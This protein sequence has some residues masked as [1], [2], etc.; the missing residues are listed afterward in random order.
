MFYLPETLINLAAEHSKLQGS[1]KLVCTQSIILKQNASDI[2]P[3]ITSVL[4][5]GQSCRLKSCWG[6]VRSA[7]D[8][9]TCKNS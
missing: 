5:L 6:K 1:L 9:N 7:V 3:C 2:F 8:K 4:L